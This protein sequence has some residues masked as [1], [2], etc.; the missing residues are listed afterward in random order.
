MSGVDST[1]FSVAKTLM[2]HSI[3]MPSFASN[4]IRLAIKRVSA[5]SKM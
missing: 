4:A 1:V 5:L 3:V 2:I